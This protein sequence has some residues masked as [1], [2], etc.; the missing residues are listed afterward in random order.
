MAT[1][2]GMQLGSKRMLGEILMERG[3][4]DR[5]QLRLA[6]VH[7]HET[8]V[9]LGR[10][11]VREG[12]CTE[13]DVL[14]AL[15]EQL[16]VPAIDLHREPLNPKLTKLVPV[17]IARQYRVVPL[18][19]EKGEREV[20]HVALPAPASLEALDAVRAISGKPR[21]EP[22]LASDSGLS[23]ALGVLYGIQEHSDEPAFEPSPASGPGA[24]ILLY[25]WPPVTATLISRALARQ[26]IQTK[27]ATPLEVM[28]TGPGDLVFAPVQAM[29][30]LLAGEA[31]IAGSLLLS[32]SSEDEELERAHRLGA[33]GYVSN[34]LDGEM[35]LRAIRR[36]RSSSDDSSQPLSGPN[37]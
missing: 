10:A 20:L 28:H 3:V 21:V 15:S 33:K 30:G 35:L 9:P 4:I 18:R 25:A 7:H 26:G 27:V 14:R 31:H 12:V 19:L 5:A 11:L 24:P 17:R 16:D 37:G 8:R 34:P 13:D 29:E 2:P 36:L 32:G 1:L 23:R 22:Y 6:L